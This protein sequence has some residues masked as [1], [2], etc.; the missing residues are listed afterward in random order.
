MSNLLG[1]NI[2]GCIGVN[3]GKELIRVVPF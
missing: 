3:L 1:H 2:I